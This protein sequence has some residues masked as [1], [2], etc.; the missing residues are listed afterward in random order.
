MAIFRGSSVRVAMV[1]TT[2]LLGSSVRVAFSG[3]LNPSQ[4]RL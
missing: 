1:M 2:M 3:P 4:G